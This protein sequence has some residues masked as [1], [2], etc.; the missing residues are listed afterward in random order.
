MPAPPVLQRLVR[1][2]QLLEERSQAA[3]KSANGYLNDLNAAAE[4]ARTRK[5]SGKSLFACGAASEDATDRVAGLCEAQLA[6]AQE[7]GLSERIRQARV[8]V[9]RQLAEL[10]AAHQERR[11][12]ELLLDAAARQAETETKRQLQKE[13]DDLHRIRPKNPS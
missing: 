3:L 10:E 2:R 4:H 6:Q 12:G 9:Q 1:L 7:E 8:S 5:A 11:K 13:L